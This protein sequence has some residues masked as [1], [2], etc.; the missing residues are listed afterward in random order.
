MIQK[1]LFFITCSLLFCGFFG[2]SSSYALLWEDLGLNLYK[3]IDEWLEE[4]ELKQYHYE[5]RAQSNS[6]SNIIEKVNS[7]LE[8]NNVEC[9]I[10]TPG[11]IDLIANASSTQ[12]QEVLKK[13]SENP[14]QISNIQANNIIDSVS[15]VRDSLRNRAEEKSKQIYS[16]SRI[17]LYSDGTT[18]NSPFDLM[19]DLEEIDRVIFSEEIE[20]IWEDYGTLDF[21]TELDDFIDWEDSIQEAYLA[22]LAPEGWNIPSEI[23]ENEL[24]T[25]TG[26][27]DD[28][29]NPEII[30]EEWGSIFTTEDGHL[31]ACYTDQDGSW[32][33]ETTLNWLTDNIHATNTI[34]IRNIYENWSSWSESLT[35]NT[36]ENSSARWKRILDKKPRFW[37]N[38]SYTPQHDVWGCESFFCITLGFVTKQQN[39][40]WAWW[41]WQTVSIESVLSKVDEH[42]Y[43]FSNTSLIQSK[44]TTNN[45][46][47]GLVIPDLWDMLRWFWMEIQS[48]P[49]PILDIDNKDGEENLE[50]DTFTQRWILN[51]YY[52]NLGL[53]YNRINNMDIYEQRIIESKAIQDTAEL[54]TNEVVNRLRDAREYSETQAEENK[55]LALAVENKVAYDELED[56]YEQFIELE[57]FTVAIKDF[58]IGVSAYIKEM[59]K[60]PTQKS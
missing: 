59:T 35:A 20:Y 58:S 17:G 16:I 60:I 44:M 30:E 13:C 21:D 32:F 36:S 9:D 53:D 43:H 11:D 7:I 22:S 8:T 29:E 26:E 55:S 12:M 25:N 57:K 15:K 28:I 46:E 39:L 52:K 24:G 50:G 47:I 4:L 23:E 3:S 19:I 33:D 51:A 31:Y 49:I 27:E 34:E 40:L 5:L 14:D 48:K 42:L 18:D 2:I 56:F 41:G 38:S 37:P 1:V 54:S 45:F 6:D 10:K